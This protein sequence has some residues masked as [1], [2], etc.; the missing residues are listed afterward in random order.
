[1]GLPSVWSKYL[2]L[3]T[4]A[5]LPV[6]LFGPAA[7]R[8]ISRLL[9]CH[10]KPTRLRLRVP[11]KG[12]C[13]LV[14]FVMLLSPEGLETLA[15]AEAQYANLGTSSWGQ[16][17]RTIHYSYDANGSL[18]KKIIALTG[19]ADPNN[20]YIEKYEYTYNLANR[21]RTAICYSQ[22]GD[23]YVKTF[24]IYTYNDEG[25]RVTSDSERYVD[26]YPAYEGYELV[27]ERSTTYL[28]DSYNHTGYAQTLEEQTVTTDY[29]DGVPQTPVTQNITY[30]IGDDVIAQR[31]DG[32]TQYLLYD[33]HG[34]TRQLAEYDSAVTIVD[35]YSYDGYGVLLQNESVASQRPGYTSPQATSILYTGEFFDTDAQQYYLRA[36]WYDSLTGRFNQIDPFAGNL[37]DPQSLHKYLYANAN[38]VMY[39]DPTGQFSIMELTSV[40]TII[41]IAVASLGPAVLAGYETAKAGAS[42][43]EI[44]ASAMIAW[45]ASFGLGVGLAL[46]MPV[47]LSLAT[48]LA[49]SIGISSSTA[50][51]TLLL[52]FASLIFYNMAEFW[53]SPDYP[54]WV[55]VVF[56]ATVV[57][58][59]AVSIGKDGLKQIAYKSKQFV[60]SLF[61]R[62]RP[63]S[64]PVITKAQRLKL[65]RLRGN[66]YRDEVGSL[67]K[68]EGY[69]IRFERRYDTP[70]GRRYIDIE[71]SKDAK[72]L[73][74]IETKVGSS[75]Y[76]P[77][78]QLKDQWLYRVKGYVV[79]VVRD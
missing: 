22:E 79:T 10:S 24:T 30:L 78:Q 39:T 65:N 69:D 71:V 59:I 53:R 60:R 13:L 12:I 36:R 67:M 25:I 16:A 51:I 66:A 38:P 3:L 6:M 31:V 19:Q 56:T 76:M 44:G 40:N 23:D 63:S 74:G 34:S 46:L 9:F 49:G 62:Q 57:A 32:V 54:L 50:Q 21:L 72:V 1:M 33:G 26:Y 70:Y 52:T 7:K 45:G 43:W 8:I 77:D 48:G 37:Q 4:I 27:E 11:K 73:G 28:V 64:N 41:A 58:S 42:W 61:S 17:N 75:R 2:I 15:R 68:K 18:E 29:I 5:L 14:A 47:A 55:K 35:T 20:N